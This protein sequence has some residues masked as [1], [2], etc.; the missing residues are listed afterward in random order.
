MSAE[1]LKSKFVP[2]FKAAGE[3]KFYRNL[4]VYATNQMMNMEKGLHKGTSPEMV[5]LGCYDQFIILYRR[6]GEA[7]YLDLARAFRKAAHK[8]YRVMLK[9]NMTQRSSRFLNLV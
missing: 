3:R 2:S 6:E 5:L 1:A 4:L 9:K 8:I 7:I